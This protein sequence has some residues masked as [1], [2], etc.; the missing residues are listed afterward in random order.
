MSKLSPKFLL[1]FNEMAE[2][3]AVY[4]LHT[5]QP[6]FLAKHTPNGPMSDFE[7]LEW[8][9]APIAFYGPDAAV[10]LAGLMRRM[11]D[12]WVAYKEF[13]NNQ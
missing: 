4:V 11:G 9:D 6:K 2:K 13:I 3:G 7:V 1:C 8:Y 10:K 5:Q 12:W